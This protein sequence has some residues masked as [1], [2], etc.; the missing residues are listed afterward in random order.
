MASA[1]V[2]FGGGG[3]VGSGPEHCGM[4]Q[5]LNRRYRVCGQRSLGL[6]SEVTGSGVTT[7]VVTGGLANLEVFQGLVWF[8]SPGTWTWCRVPSLLRPTKNQSGPV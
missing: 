2:L 3:G 4:G 5:A 8:L 1:A 6:R 7:S